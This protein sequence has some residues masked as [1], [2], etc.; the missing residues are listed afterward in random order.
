MASE[1]AGK[2]EASSGFNLSS[3]GRFG[4]IF[5]VLFVGMAVGRL[6]RYSRNQ[7]RRNAAV[8]LTRVSR[9]VSAEWFSLVVVNAIIAS[10]MVSV[11]QITSQFTLT[12][13]LWNLAGTLFEPMIQAVAGFLPD[14]PVGAIKGLVNWFNANQLKFSFWL[15]YS[16]AICDDLGLP[17][18]K[19]LGRFLSRRL[20][21]RRQPAAATIPPV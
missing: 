13:V 12:K 6:M 2:T 11:L 10:V 17:N 19:T 1:S 3:R 18:Y 14:G 9:R 20:K 8:W 4:L 16:A 5:A 15:L 21:K 7:E